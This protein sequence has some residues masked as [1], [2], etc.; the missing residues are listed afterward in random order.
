MCWVVR[1]LLFVV[2][3]LLFVVLVGGCS[4]FSCL[5]VYWRVVVCCCCCLCCVLCVVARLGCAV[6][7][8]FDGG[9]VVCS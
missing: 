6:V 2:S 4:S 8:L 5:F 1:C 3:C 9:V 7:G